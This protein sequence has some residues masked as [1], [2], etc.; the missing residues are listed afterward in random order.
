MTNEIWPYP[1]IIAHRGGGNLAP[2]NTLTAIDCGHRYGHKM[3]EVDA[4]L[5]ADQQVFLLHD[6]T[7]ERTTNVEGIAGDIPWAGL[8]SADAG[9]WFAES[10]S[11]EKLPLL[12][13]V[14]E[15]CRR[16]KMMANIEIKPTAG[17]EDLTGRL[18]ARAAAEYWQGL[19]NPLLSSF[20][21]ISLKAAQLEQP[22]LPRGYLMH[23]WQDDWLSATRELGCVA[24][25]L[26]YRLLTQARIEQIKQAGL[27]ILAY[28]VNDPV[29]ARQLLGQGVDMLC[30]DRIDLIGADFA[31]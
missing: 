14:A 5:S 1:K 4:K 19:P 20:S 26:N 11:G 13:E 7:L 24:L 18:V 27:R 10:F 22:Q 15:R 17:V 2:E 9:A 23:E 21:R 16:Y 29:T 6:D 31:R 28:T 30:T 25:H 3:I 12:A 8:Q